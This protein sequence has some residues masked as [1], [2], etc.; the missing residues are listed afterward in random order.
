[1]GQGQDPKPSLTDEFNLKVIEEL[2]N[3]ESKY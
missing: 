1:M 3:L 2:E